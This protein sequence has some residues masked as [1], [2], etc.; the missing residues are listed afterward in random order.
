MCVWNCG[1]CNVFADLLQI[2]GVQVHCDLRRGHRLLH[3]LL[4]DGQHLSRLPFKLLVDE[5]SR[6]L[7][8]QIGQRRE[9]IHA[10]ALKL[11]HPSGPEA[12]PGAGVPRQLPPRRSA[13]PA[14]KPSRAAVARI[15]SASSACLL[16]D[17]LRFRPRPLQHG[18][19]RRR[20]AMFARSDPSALLYRERRVHP[21]GWW[22]WG[23]RSW[24]WEVK[25]GARVGPWGLS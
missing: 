1:A 22:V 24:W 7:G 5:L 12:Q 9:S 14:A 17:P 23:S 21:Q 3:R 16:D 15:C 18:F 20:L 10:E 4:N 25:S 8:R 6:C 13:R 2:V 19:G 11:W